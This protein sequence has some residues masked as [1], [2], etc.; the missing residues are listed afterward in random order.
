L[1]CNS[2]STITAVSVASSGLVTLNFTS[3]PQLS[4]NDAIEIFSGVTCN[5]NC[6]PT[7][8]SMLT[9]GRTSSDGVKIGNVLT[10]VVNSTTSYT[11]TIAGFVGLASPP[12]FDIDPVSKAKW[13][14]TSVMGV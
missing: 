2:V 8:L 6:N 7:F 12:T 1:V 10:K 9:E 3:A 11:S 14:R 4:T 5:A 13:R